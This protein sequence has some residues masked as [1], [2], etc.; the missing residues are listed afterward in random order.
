[1]L[2]SLR[3]LVIWLRQSWGRRKTECSLAHG[4]T[5]AVWR[6]VTVVA[7]EFPRRR[8][9]IRWPCGF[10]RRVLFSMQEHVSKE[11]TASIFRQTSTYL[12]IWEDHCIFFF[13]VCSWNKIVILQSAPKYTQSR[14]VFVAFW[15]PLTVANRSDGNGK[16][17]TQN[18]TCQT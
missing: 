15:M 6:H 5:E 14:R 7:L 11:H 16:N 12:S 17:V 8:E 18:F 1:M 2:G 3:P 4:Q 13:S 10:L 9:Y